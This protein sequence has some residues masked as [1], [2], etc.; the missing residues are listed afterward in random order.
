M[1]NKDID[2][3]N[4]AEPNPEKNE[5]PSVWELVVD[6]MQSRNEFGIGK[7]GTPLQPFNGRNQLKDAYQEVLDLAVYMRAAIFEMD[8]MRQMQEES[9]EGKLIKACREMVEGAGTF[10]GA[11]C[12]Y[13]DLSTYKAIEGLINGKSND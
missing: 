3:I 10:T 12:V 7:Y 11:E 9:L 4:N 2:N 6:D 8:V 5:L 13:I 1:S